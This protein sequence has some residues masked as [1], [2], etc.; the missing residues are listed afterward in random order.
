MQLSDTVNA[1]LPTAFFINSLAQVRN[2]LKKATDIQKASCHKISAIVYCKECTRFF[3]SECL[4]KH[5]RWQP[6]SA[7][8]II[9]SQ[10]VA[11]NAPNPL[12]LDEE[13]GDYQDGSLKVYY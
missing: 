9:N 10:G 3:C 2:T 8:E 5:N 12:P 4:D 11:V 13:K 6:F 7:H 1:E